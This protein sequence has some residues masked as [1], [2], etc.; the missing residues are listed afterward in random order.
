MQEPK[1]ISLISMYNRTSVIKTP[2]VMWHNT[3]IGIHKNLQNLHGFF[4]T[5]IM[6]QGVMQMGEDDSNVAVL[7]RTEAI[8]MNDYASVTSLSSDT[9]PHVIARY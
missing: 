1:E 9:F 7:I 4:C 3:F 8:H 6:G 5:F 2:K